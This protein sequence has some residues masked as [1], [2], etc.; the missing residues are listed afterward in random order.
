VLFTKNQRSIGSHLQS[1]LSQALQSEGILDIGA[2]EMPLKQ[3]GDDLPLRYSSAIALKFAPKSSCSAIDLAERLVRSLLATQ[4]DFSVAVTS[5]GWITLQ[6]TDRAI[7]DWLQFVL[8]SFPQC[9]LNEE[10]SPK[11]SLPCFPA[12][13]AHARCYTL[14]QLAYREGA[15]GDSLV[16][17]RQAIVPTHIPW[18]DPDRQCLHVDRPAERRL[19][20][21][22][23]H[24]ADALTASQPQNYTKLALRLSQR[25]E[26]F[27]SHCRFLGTV[28][29]VNPR[30]ASVRIGLLGVTQTL[31]Q[32]LLERKLRISSPIAL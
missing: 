18:L 10:S 26:E 31:L 16:G 11:N 2:S 8:Q 29:T 24:T 14:L 7:A 25:F 22:L 28:K 13:Y 23:V 32:Y 9:P 21:Q 6:L 15:I 1:Q 5:T 17:D 4:P 30:L 19:I 27:Y 12:Q 20:S 3:D